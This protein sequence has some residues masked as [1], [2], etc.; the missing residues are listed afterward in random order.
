MSIVSGIVGPVVQANAAKK[1]AKTQA[2]ATEAAA[3]V[4]LQAVQEAIAAERELFEI[5]REDL[6]PYREVGTQA[7]RD[8]AGT[9]DPRGGFPGERAFTFD[10]PTE[11]FEGDPGYQ[12]RLAEGQKAIERSAAARGGLLSGRTL[13]DIER[14]A[15]GTA[16]VEFQR[17]YGR[18]F[19]EALTEYESGR[20]NLTE[21]F[22]R[23]AAL[24]GIGQTTSTTL[25]GLGQATGANIGRTTLSGGQTVA[26]LITQGANARASGYAAQG[27]ATGQAIQNTGQSLANLYATYYLDG[28]G[29]T[30]SPGASLSSQQALGG[31][32]T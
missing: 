3:D 19:Q 6:A 8:L 31:S 13:K 22:N 16:S 9:L 10:F 32:F 2:R 23:L 12:F 25:A 5:S 30:G 28:G 20:L 15:Q 14:F 7:L 11:E 21:R 1:A 29:G 27:F 26:D 17:A 24:A 4:S 18:Q